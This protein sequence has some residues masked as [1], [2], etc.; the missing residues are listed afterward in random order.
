MKICIPV[1]EDRG[2]ESP[3]SAHFGSAPLFAVVDTE[4]DAC[5]T[6]ANGDR[7]HGHGMCRP[8]A[9]LSGETIDGVIVGGI[10]KGALGKLQASGIRVF[11]A[12]QATVRDA[13]AAFK[14]GA[15]HE[16]TQATACAHDGHGPHGHGQ[17]GGGPHG[18][19]CGKSRQPA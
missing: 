4:S 10:G 8:L 14:T 13:L 12:Q 18:R 5:R 19:C 16:A 9:A 11:L 1:T 15:L 6:I 3:L 17:G 7:H 2:S